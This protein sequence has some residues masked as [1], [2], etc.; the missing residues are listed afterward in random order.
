M[1]SIHDPL[2]DVLRSDPTPLLRLLSALRPDL[3][4]TGWTAR[5][6][7]S[8]RPKGPQRQPDLVLM[9]PDVP[10]VLIVEL[11]LRRDERKL[12]TWPYY[13]ATAE[14]RH[15]CDAMLVVV[16]LSRGVATWARGP[17]RKL[18]GRL[19]YTVVGPDDLP[20]P[21]GDPA[22]LV[23]AA[24]ARGR[25][26]RGLVER[27]LV[28]LGDVDEE[29]AKMYLGLLQDHLPTIAAQILE[30]MMNARRKRA[31]SVERLLEEFSKMV[32]R[33]EG[34]IEGKLEG[35]LE[36]RLEGKLEGEAE[37]ARRARREDVS[38]LLR[39]LRRDAEIEGLS[40][41]ELPALDVLF[42]QLLDELQAPA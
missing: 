24:L 10:L 33:E 7:S 11:Q 6:E 5:S 42:E 12:R 2:L 22:M 26:D 35:K 20:D 34:K 36:G 39:R 1:A 27:A 16:T 21:G 3:P 17:H 14:L 9:H 32:G 18:W 29:R 25:R 30:L 15:G 4:L 28:S 23:L 31:E 37:G 40:A 8:G 38:R 41:L 19:E 13:A